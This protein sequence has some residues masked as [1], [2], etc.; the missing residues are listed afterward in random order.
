M[1]YLFV[2]LLSFALL[3]C[4]ST[5]EAVLQTSQPALLKTIPLPA[6]TTNVHSPGMQ[7]NVLF[8][9]LSDGTVADVKMLGSSG[10]RIWDS[11]AAKSMTQW[12]FARMRSDEKP[13]E[14]WVRYAVVV[15]PQTREPIVLMLGAISAPTIQEADSLYTLLANGVD[16][17]TLAKELYGTSSGDHGGFLGAVD[18]ALYPSNVREK[19]QELRENEISRPIKVGDRY[20]IYKRFKDNIALG[21]P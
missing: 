8:H 3:G 2:P 5:N 4:T 19:L 6:L 12:R 11:L 16:F 14:R 1:R 13:G 17:D 21:L 9:I 18:V 10:D 15:Q 7:L 20:V